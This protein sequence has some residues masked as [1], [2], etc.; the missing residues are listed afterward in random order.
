MCLFGRHKVKIGKHINSKIINHATYAVGK[1]TDLT[2]EAEYISELDQGFD[3]YAPQ[4][5][6]VWIIKPTQCSSVGLVC[7]I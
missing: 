2:F 1:L 6:A 4:T 3:F 7:Q 5:S